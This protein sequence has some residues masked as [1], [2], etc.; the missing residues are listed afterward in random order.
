M[1]KLILII[2]ALFS[3]KDWKRTPKSPS[4]KTSK[5]IKW[6]CVWNGPNAIHSWFSFVSHILKYLPYTLKNKDSCMA[7]EPLK[8]IKTFH[9]AKGSLRVLQI[10]KMDI[11]AYNFRTFN[12]KSVWKRAACIL[13]N[14]SFLIKYDQR[15]SCCF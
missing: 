7:N 13:P 14:A 1:Y 11:N 2:N 8:S 10:I 5:V 6:L 9:C 15:V 3:N 4:T 12:F